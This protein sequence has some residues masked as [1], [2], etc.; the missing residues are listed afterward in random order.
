M[1]IIG[2]LFRKSTEIQYKKSF[3]KGKDYNNQL[4]TLYKLIHKAEETR[5]GKNFQFRKILKSENI[6]EDYQKV[7]PITYYEEF[8]D[9]WLAA[10]IEGERNHTWPGRINFF[11]LSSGT[12]AAASKRIPITKQMIRSFQKTSMN[13]SSIFYSLNLPEAFYEAKFLTIGGSTKL[14][15][16]NNYYE[17]DL[18]GILKKNT[19]FIFNTF[20]KPNN[21]ITKISDWNKKIKK[22]V[23]KAPN[24][25]IGT[26]AGVPSWCLMVMEKIVE[27][28]DLKNIHEIWPNLEVYLHG[29]V[30]MEPYK[31][32]LDKLLGREIHLMNTYLASEGYFAYQ[33]RFDREGMQ[34]LLGSGVFYEFIPFSRDFFDEQ[35][36]LRDKYTAFNLS[37]VKPDVDYA[38]VI[39]TN[40]G[41]WRYMIGDL[42][43]FTD[44]DKHEIKI[45]GRI[46]QY[47]SLVGEH[48]SLQNINEAISKIAKELKIQIDEFTINADLEKMHHYWYIGT[49][50]KVNEKVFIQKIDEELM[51]LNDDYK[52]CRKHNLS[53]PKIKIFDSSIFYD[54]MEASGKLGS[55]NKFPRVMNVEQSENWK[56]FISKRGV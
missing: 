24:W 8:Y 31:A 53:D 51:R 45:T 50:S 39:T 46:R 52:T 34:L 7:V 6:V 4:R 37:Q 49:N 1:P 27:H 28:Y 32:R 19:S 56:N 29:G 26:I 20:T 25:D 42:V 43:R 33:T 16:I 44:I 18:S 2:K 47:L 48:L 14:K 12:T 13:Q 54:F 55:Q 23:E 9:K 11:A 17:G 5:F 15:K 3:K 10:T 40:A 35:G 36:N 41:L 22:I 21:N 38:L 30:Y